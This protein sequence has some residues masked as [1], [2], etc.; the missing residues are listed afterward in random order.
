MFRNVEEVMT[1]DVPL[2]LPRFV[3]TFDAVGG[4]D[5]MSLDIRR[6]CCFV[7]KLKIIFVFDFSYHLTIGDFLL[8]IPFEL[9]L[10]HRLGTNLYHGKLICSLD[11]FQLLEVHSQHF[12]PLTYSMEE[13][14][15]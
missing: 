9:L 13:S 5:S 10:P 4:G 8:L 12:L 14:S 15:S 3:V 11:K 6:S 2:G 7:L 1:F